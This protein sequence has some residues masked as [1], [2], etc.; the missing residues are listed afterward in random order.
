VQYNPFAD[1]ERP[2]N[3]LKYIAGG[4]ALASV[5]EAAFIVLLLMNRPGPLDAVTIAAAP[6]LELRSSAAAATVGKPA[7]VTPPP[8][9]APAP[10][11]PPAPKT[12]AA[13]VDATPVAGRFGGIRVTAPIDIQVFEG[14]ALIGSSAGPIAVPDGN[15]TLDLVSEALGYRSRQTV[16]VKPGQ[17]VP[18]KVTLPQGRININAAPWANVWIDGNAAGET[19]IANLAITIG[20]H[21][22]VFRHPQL[23]EQKQTVVVKAEGLTRVSANLQQR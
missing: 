6:P 9:P 14:G 4:F 7:A 17:M 15:H 19:P 18:V 1:E 5:I 21:E 11:P 16:S 8:A 23:G 22:I 13:P 10:E 20:S 2:N 3:K 12:E